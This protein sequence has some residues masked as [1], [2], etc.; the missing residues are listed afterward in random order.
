MSRRASI[1]IA[2]ALLEAVSGISGVRN[3]LKSA[4]ANSSACKSVA[5]ST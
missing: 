2:G 5:A 4:F 3:E 1:R